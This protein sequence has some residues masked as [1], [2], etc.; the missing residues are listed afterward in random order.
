MMTKLISYSCFCQLQAGLDI[1]QANVS[2]LLEK[3]VRTSPP[4][5]FILLSSPSSSECLV[6]TRRRAAALIVVV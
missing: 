1:T 3:T 5:V 2:R 6:T 4:Y